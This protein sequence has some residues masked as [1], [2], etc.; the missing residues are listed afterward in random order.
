MK[1]YG[2]S[3]MEYLASR[4]VAQARIL[5][6]S[7]TLSI[8][9]IAFRCGFSDPYYFTKV[10]TKRTGLCPTRYRALARPDRSVSSEEDAHGEGVT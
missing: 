8:K 1:A 2:L 5:L 3:P 9:E 7:T 4:R 6:F 10:F